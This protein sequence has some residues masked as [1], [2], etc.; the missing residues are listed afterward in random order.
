[1]EAKDPNTSSGQLE[2]GASGKQSGINIIHA[3]IL[4]SMPLSLEN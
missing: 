2:L 1:M 3:S 4:A